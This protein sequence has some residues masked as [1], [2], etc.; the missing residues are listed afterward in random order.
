MKNLMLFLH[1]TLLCTYASSQNTFYSVGHGDWA[2]PNNWSIT[3]NGSGP[4]GPPTA[5]DDIIIRD[6]IYQITQT[7]YKHFGNIIIEEA[8]VF[9][10]FSGWGQSKVYVFAGSLMDIY[11]TLF[12]NGDFHQQEAGS[13]G[14][15]LLILHP[16]GRIH[17]GDDLIMNANASAIFDN[18]E[19]GKAYACDDLY[20]VGTGASLCGEGSFLLD[21]KVRIWDNLGNETTNY[22]AAINSIKQQVCQ[23]F[24]IYDSKDDCENDDPL[25]VGSDSSFP[26]EFVELKSK[27]TPFGIEISWETASETN[28]DYFTLEK[29]R[30]GER[31]EVVTRMSGS[32]TTNTAQEYRFLD[33]RAYQG[34]SWYR[35]R[36]T[37]FDGTSSYSSVIEVFYNNDIIQF[38]TFPNPVVNQ[39]FFNVKIQG[40]QSDIPVRITLHDL[41]GRELSV[42][43]FRTDFS[44][45]LEAKIPTQVPAGEYMVVIT[46]PT[47]RETRKLVIY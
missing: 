3:E 33:D 28:N 2:N 26:V 14:S 11:G 32:G 15:G 37:D 18:P 13:G 34:K 24:P 45:R 31:F 36:Q 27:P 10:I 17:M 5:Q 29:S 22:S 47:Q 4:A 43:S 20:F 8:G 19:C 30:D 7:G 16:T 41:Q 39:S 23:N 21:G 35:V 44:G 25:L 40:G 12:T 46:T 1:L 38:T 9:S 6:S 42:T